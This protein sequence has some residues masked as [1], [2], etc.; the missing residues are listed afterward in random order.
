MSGQG[1]W[2]PV[3]LV[4]GVALGVAVMA[5]WSVRYWQRFRYKK[6]QLTCPHSNEQVRIVV[7]QEVARDERLEVEH[8]TSSLLADPDCVDC[9][10]ACL[11]DIP[12]KA[13]VVG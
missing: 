6:V 4:F 8:C 11:S 7:R 3:A 2:L 10:K 5:W 12:V 1:H 13:G 9:Q